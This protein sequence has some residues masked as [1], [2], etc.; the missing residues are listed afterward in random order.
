MILFIQGTQNNFVKIKAIINPE[1]HMDSN[2]SV[3][4]K[5]NIDRK[6]NKWFRIIRTNNEQI[7][8]GKMPFFFDRLIKTAARRKNPKRLPKTSK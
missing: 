5:Y 2:P 6:S 3:F 7:V 1:F 8:E 4:G